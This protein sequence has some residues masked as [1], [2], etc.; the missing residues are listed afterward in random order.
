MAK[1]VKCPYCE[2]RVDKDDAVTH[3]KRYYHEECFNTWEQDKQHRKDL[4]EYIC[5]LYQIE[6]PTGII[7]KQIKD[8]QENYKYKLKGIEL[9][10]K[11]FHETLRKPVREGDGIGIVPF[12]Y[13]DAK[14]HYL[15]K[16]KVEDSL[17]NIDTD[18]I[19]VKT[20]AISSS[21]LNY[22]KQ[23]KK[24]DIASL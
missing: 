1:L 6:V 14:K 21:G 8:F 18:S 20:I 11:Y 15:M 5:D 22:K 3:S 7:L 10:L 24:I 19:E 2:K 13:E 9:A 16:L 12:V 23:S 17:E 4:I